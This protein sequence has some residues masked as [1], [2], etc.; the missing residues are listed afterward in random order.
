MAGYT[1]LREEIAKWLSEFYEHPTSES[2]SSL[3]STTPKHVGK[4]RIATV[5]DASRI[6]ISGGASQNLVCALQVFS[7][8]L[9]TTAWMVAPCGSRAWTCGGNEARK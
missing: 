4:E 6:C 5:P 3:C 2:I 7:D 8:P 1:P 9:V